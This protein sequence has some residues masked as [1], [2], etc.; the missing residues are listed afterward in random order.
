MSQQATVQ[1]ETWH[2]PGPG[3]VVILRTDGRGDLVVEEM[4]GP[5]RNFVL[6]SAEREQMQRLAYSPE[7]DMFSNGTLMPVHLI[8]GSQMAREAASNPNLLSDGDMRTLVTGKGKS[9]P[10]A[11]A[12]FEEKLATIANATTLG[13]LLSLAEAEDAPVSRVR[14][15][16]RRL[17]E[18]EGV[19]GPRPAEASIDGPA[20][21]AGGREGPVS[22]A[23]TPR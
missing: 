7:Q 10:A 11:A 21:A 14:A 5:E 13:R 22:R 15:I 20:A 4:V 18:V 19:G 17:S 8:E 3:R 1:L 23:V 2:N 12:A 16:Q 9:K 6:A